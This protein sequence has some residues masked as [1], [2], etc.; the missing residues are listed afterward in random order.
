MA[1]EITHDIQEHLGVIYSTVRG[2]S[3]GDG[4][5]KE[6]NI[7][8]WNG[9]IPKIDIRDWNEDHDR[10]SKGIALTESEAKELME[11]LQNYFKKDAE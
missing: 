1:K 2:R 5:T 7:V 8:A 3:Q 10:C 4:W 6:V 9:G 11:I